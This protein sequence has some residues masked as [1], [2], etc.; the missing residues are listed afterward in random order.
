MINN[1][2][3]GIHLYKVDSL[4][5]PKTMKSDF[6][7]HWATWRKTPNYLK[8]KGNWLMQADD[9]YSKCGRGGLN[10]H[11]RFRKYFRMQ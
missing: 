2:S 4:R 1:D 5:K 6:L 11:C 7:T 9:R 10:I 3:A 8:S